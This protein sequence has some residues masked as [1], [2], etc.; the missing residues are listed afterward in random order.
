VKQTTLRSICRSE[1]RWPP[2]PHSGSRRTWMSVPPPWPRPASSPSRNVSPA[3]LGRLARRGLGQPDRLYVREYLAP[4]YAKAYHDYG[5]PPSSAPPT[6]ATRASMNGRSARVSRSSDE[7]IPGYIN[8]GTWPRGQADLRAA[9]TEYQETHD[10]KYLVR[11]VC[12]NSEADLEPLAK[13]LANWRTT[14]AG[15]SRSATTSATR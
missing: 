13:Q 14:A 6:G 2:R 15:S 9:A 8:V 12:L 11:P 10:K 7:R 1:S 5:Y 4:G 3:G